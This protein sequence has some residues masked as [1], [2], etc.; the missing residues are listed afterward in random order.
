MID[1]Y[2]DM[3]GVIAKYDPNAYKEPNPIWLDP[4]KHYFRTVEPDPRMADVAVK[5]VNLLAKRDRN[6]INITSC[7][8][9]SSLAKTGS[10][11]KMQ[12]EDKCAWLDENLGIHMSVLLIPSITGKRHT[13]ES[14]QNKNLSAKDVLIDDFN[15]NLIEWREAGG[16]AIKYLNGINDKDSFDGIVIDQAMT[17]NDII[18]MLKLIDKG[19]QHQ[20][21]ERR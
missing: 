15:S 19:L 17:A 9:L 8:F 10:M 18:D 21:R 3:D 5:L 13:I 4:D 16:T 2:I 1:C 12:Y 11:M 6:D 20:Y 14:R 7:K